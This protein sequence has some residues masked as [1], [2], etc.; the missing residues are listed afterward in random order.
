MQFAGSFGTDTSQWMLQQSRTAIA[1]PETTVIVSWIHSHVRGT[2][3]GFSSIDVHTQYGYSLSFPNL[4]G[5]VVEIQ[6]DGTPISEAFTLTAQGNAIVKT[7]SRANNL[8]S[9]QHEGC[10]L[11]SMYQSVTSVVFYT[12]DEIEVID[13]RKSAPFE[14]NS[15]MAVD[16]LQG[17]VKCE[18]CGKI[19]Q[20]P[21]LLRHIGRAVRCKTFYG[22]RFVELKKL[23]AKENSKKYRT[24]NAE[25]VAD[26]NSR[27]NRTNKDTIK[28]KQADYD[29]KNKA[30]VVEKQAIYDKQNQQKV[31]KKQSRYNLKN[32]EKIAKRQAEYDLKNSEK[33]TQRQ[34]E[35]N[36]CHQKEIAEKQQMKRYKMKQERTEDDRLMYFKH[37]IKDGPSFVCC[38]C[39][40]LLFRQSVQEL[41][42]DCIMDL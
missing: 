39:Q 42:D 23:R 19:L 20:K 33:I 2:K 6:D 9:L 21:S 30:K 10:S 5:L 28:V 36:L 1:N 13:G 4:L 35:Y 17:D 25:K 18:S 38:C 41:T 16:L 29:Q 24:E 15:P 40:K 11:R 7:C 22:P 34:A 27:Y 37:D 32:S 3:C 8:S 31:V 14:E 12:T 26:D